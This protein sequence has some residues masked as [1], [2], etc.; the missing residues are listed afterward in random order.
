MNLAPH[1]ID[2]L[3]PILLKMIISFGVPEHLL[4]ATSLGILDRVFAQ[5]IKT[6]T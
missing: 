2:Q 6:S 5:I 4:D 1:G 3:Q